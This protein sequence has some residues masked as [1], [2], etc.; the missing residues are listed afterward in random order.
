MLR[1]L[2]VMAR[3]LQGPRLEDVNMGNHVHAQSKGAMCAHART[4]IRALILML[5]ETGMSYETVEEELRLQWRNGNTVHDYVN[6]KTKKAKKE[7]AEFHKRLIH[8]QE[9]IHHHVGS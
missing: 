3:P 1:P 6:C 9:S 2:W 7:V 4:A 8:Q 5:Q